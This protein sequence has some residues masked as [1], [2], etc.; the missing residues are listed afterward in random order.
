[1]FLFDYCE[2]DTKPQRVKKNRHVK[3]DD[4]D[5]NSAKIAAISDIINAVIQ[6]VNA[7][8]PF[9]IIQVLPISSSNSKGFLLLCS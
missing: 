2:M 3:A 9:N 1:M 5:Q 4:V 6:S 8:K 7:N